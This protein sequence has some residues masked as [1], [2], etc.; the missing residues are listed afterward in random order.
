MWI[1]LEDDLVK[2]TPEMIQDR[3][4]LP[5]KALHV[6]LHEIEDPAIS[7]LALAQHYSRTSRDFMLASFYQ[8]RSDGQEELNYK[9][10]GILFPNLATAH[11][12]ANCV[13]GNR[14]F[15]FPPQIYSLDSLK[16]A[17]R[18]A[19]GVEFEFVGTEGFGYWENVVAKIP[20]LACSEVK[21]DGSIDYDCTGC[22]DCH[23]DDDECDCSQSEW[24]ME[25]ATPPLQFNLTTRNALARLVRAISDAGYTNRSCGMHIHV[26]CRDWWTQPAVLGNT[27]WNLM[28]FWQKHGKEYVELLP[29][30][31][32]DNHYCRAIAALD[33]KYCMVNMSSI[34]SKGTIEYRA[35]PA[36]LRMDSIWAWIRFC[37]SLTRWAVDNPAGEHVMPGYAMYRGGE[38]E[39]TLP[40][41]KKI[42]KLL[43][44]NKRLTK[45]L[46][47]GF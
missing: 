39:L 43:R 23:N 30:H 8:M 33:E 7:E 1:K 40:S 15:R 32:Q 24:P 14:A 34:Q 19:F 3:W 37:L 35:A 4:W 13:F 10:P 44:L 5:F 42:P 25:I 36:T 17:P 41:E 12:L 26:S 38:S 47:G 11:L 31:R 28:K 29:R 2:Y 46:L 16:P 20:L 9:R 18:F 45:Q 6:P 27:G 21:D 22:R